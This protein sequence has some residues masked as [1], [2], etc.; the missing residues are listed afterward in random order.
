MFLFSFPAQ[1]HWVASTTKTVEKIVPA[2]APQPHVLPVIDPEILKNGRNV[3]EYTMPYTCFV[4]APAVE[5]VSPTPERLRGCSEHG[6]TL[7]V[8]CECRRCFSRVCGIHAASPSN[9]V[10]AACSL[11][12][13]AGA[14]ASGLHAGVEQPHVPPLDPVFEDLMSSFVNAD[15]EGV[16][17]FD[18]KS[19]ERLMLDVSSLVYDYN[20]R[21]AAASSAASHHDESHRFAQPEDSV[22]PDLNI[23]CVVLD[24]SGEDSSPPTPPAPPS[25]S[26]PAAIT[27]ACKPP[28]EAPPPR[29]QTLPDLPK[30]AN[31]STPTV[32]SRMLSC[33]MEGAMILNRMRLEKTP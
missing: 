1:A 30:K 9:G 7:W 3:A 12:D 6:C 10:C 20:A 31:G 33:L 24:F 14:L 16:V 18:I 29:D 8:E 15:A 13:P 32:A 23:E 17:M 26:P 21:N 2:P 27:C 28:E 19:P 4:D 22:V 25:Y 11:C 5:N